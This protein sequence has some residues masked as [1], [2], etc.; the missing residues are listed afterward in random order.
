MI[1]AAAT[2]HRDDDWGQ[3]GTMV[4]QVLNDA[5]RDRHP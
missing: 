5:A 3:A 2:P 1:R 4:R